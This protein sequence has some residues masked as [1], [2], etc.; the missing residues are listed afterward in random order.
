LSLVQLYN[1][2][3]NALGYRLVITYTFQS[4]RFGTP[5]DLKA[6][7]D[8]AHEMDLFVMLDVV[9]SHASKNV[10]DGLNSFDGT[11]ICILI[12]KKPCNRIFIP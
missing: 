7:V 6:L 3:I 12:L 1:E 8:K 11:G 10:L 4:F 2:E 9:H 5:E